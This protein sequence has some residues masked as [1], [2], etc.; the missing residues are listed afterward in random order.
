M[1]V[2]KVTRS[3]RRPK[4]FGYTQSVFQ[5]VETT[6]GTITVASAFHG[7]QEGEASSKYDKSKSEVSD[8]D[9]DNEGD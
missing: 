4:C 3:D 2:L 6:D 1:E 5:V 8:K 7:H 9:D